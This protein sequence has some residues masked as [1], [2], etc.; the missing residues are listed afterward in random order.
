MYVEKYPFMYP[1]YPKAQ[2]ITVIRRTTRII[3]VTLSTELIILVIGDV[4]GFSKVIDA[5][6]VCS[7]V[8]ILVVNIVVLDLV[9][10]LNEAVVDGD[11][12][13]VH[14]VEIG[15]VVVV[16]DVLLGA[17][18]VILAVLTDVEFIRP[19]SKSWETAKTLALSVPVL[20]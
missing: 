12:D 19:K 9:A 11:V 14:L 3:R 20:R 1:V 6:N 16:T 5:E 2:K 4:A 7:D 15:G 18:V 17:V 13:E 8:T 10:L